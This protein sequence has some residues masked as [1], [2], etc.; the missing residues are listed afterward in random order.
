MQARDHLSFSPARFIEHRLTF[1]TLL[2]KTELIEPAILF[3]GLNR[4]CAKGPRHGGGV[5]M[6]TVL[7][8]HEFVMLVSSRQNWVRQSREGNAVE[9]Q[10][11][12]GRQE[13]EGQGEGGR[14]CER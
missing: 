13:G 11:S 6:A 10:G 12:G 3:G 7:G 5:S 4:S 8:A 2:D 9:R 14:E 1:I